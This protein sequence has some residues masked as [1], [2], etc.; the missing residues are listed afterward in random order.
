[1]MVIYF[2]VKISKVFPG[3]RGQWSY[4]RVDSGTLSLST[5]IF[6]YYVYIYKYICIYIYVYMYK[7]VSILAQSNSDCML[8]V[9]LWSPTP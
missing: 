2:E 6:V 4:L 3:S 7:S 8:K 1:M 5:C 9:L